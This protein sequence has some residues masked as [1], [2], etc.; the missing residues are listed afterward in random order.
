[1]RFYSPSGASEVKTGML[2][3]KFPLA[4]LLV[5][6]VKRDRAAKPLRGCR[7]P[8]ALLLGLL[9]ESTAQQELLD[10]HQQEEKG[11]CLGSATGSRRELNTPCLMKRLIF[12][13]Q[14]HRRVLG[15]Y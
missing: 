3:T 6:G 11:K 10:S 14:E 7:R 8:R 5:A 12:L 2:S 13:F 4:A 9:V 1:L 15:W